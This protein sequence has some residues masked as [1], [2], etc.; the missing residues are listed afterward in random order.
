MWHMCHVKRGGVTNQASVTPSVTLAFS[1]TGLQIRVLCGVSHCHTV[2]APS[3]DF[4][5]SVYFYIIYF[6]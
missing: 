3:Q 6:I 2:T 1:I 5:G 4:Q